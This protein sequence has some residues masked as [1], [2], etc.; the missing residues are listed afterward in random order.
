MEAWKVS[1][2]GSEVSEG[3][4]STEL[5]RVRIVARYLRRCFAGSLGRHDCEDL[6]QDAYRQLLELE[7][8]GEEIRDRLE[9]MRTI[10]WRDARDRVQAQANPRPAD[11]QGAL[12]SRLRAAEPELEER[13]DQRAELALAI[14]AVEGLPPG[15]QAAYR[16]R[17][18]EGL[19]IAEAA[20]RLG[21]H[22]ATLCR[23]VRAAVEAVAAVRTA[24]G[25]ELACR[26]V[27]SVY[28]AGVASA[29]ERRRAERL[30]AEDPRAVAIARELRRLHEGAAAAI[31]AG[32]VDR[33][34]HPS[35][36]DH[37]AA[38]AHAARDRITGVGCDRSFGEL[39]TQASS[40]STARGAGAGAGG[41]LAHL[42]GSATTA[43]IV[44]ACLAGGAAAT[45]C[46]VT[47]LLPPVHLGSSSAPRPHAHRVAHAAPPRQTAPPAAGSETTAS[48]PPT[49]TAPAPQPAPT[50]TPP[51]QPTTTTTTPIA[52]STPPAQQEFGVAS[53]AATT[54]SSSSGAS[55]GGGGGGS[56]A[57]QQFGQP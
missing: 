13:I 36:L 52:P 48:P 2:G 44:A 15:A 9:L 12:L 17:V 41:A 28:I 53:A 54:S 38:L 23:Q 25:A 11:P 6:A 39:A 20:R 22:R 55:P 14:E 8:G 3:A 33:T 7:Q 50:P 26:R 5:D 45:T 31:P 4:A 47:G 10:A 32:V 1:V 43:K 21:V 49:Q 24:S 56:T 40:G 30:L 34:T 29:R 51:P 42:A 19:S 16:A 37:V 27:L 18:V 35:V 57:K 46:A